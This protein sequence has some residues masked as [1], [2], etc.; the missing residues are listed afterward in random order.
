MF[1]IE[2]IGFFFLWKFRRISH[3]NFL[4]LEELLRDFPVEQLQ[5]FPVKL[6]EVLVEFL[7]K[8]SVELFEKFSQKSKYEFP[9]ELSENWSA[10]LL[11]KWLL[12]LLEKLSLKLLEES[13]VALLSTARKTPKATTTG[14]SGGAPGGTSNETPKKL[15][16][17]LVVFNRYIVCFNIGFASISEIS[18]TRL[19]IWNCQFFFSLS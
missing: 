19:C 15:A 13:L 2:L 1:P 11:K 5:K 4:N 9:V 7:Q 16:S 3:W 10:E 17:F 12:E 14:I 8:L 18:R 6:K